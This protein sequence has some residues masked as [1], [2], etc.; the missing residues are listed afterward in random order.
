MCG[1]NISKKWGGANRPG[2]VSAQSSKSAYDGELTAK[3][4]S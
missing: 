1:V 4:M 2:K 3:Y